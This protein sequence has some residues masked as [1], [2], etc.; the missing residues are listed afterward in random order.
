MSAGVADERF[1][2]DPAVPSV[3]RAFGLGASMLLGRGGEASVY[4]LDEERV[5]RIHRHGPTETTIERRA[6]L[7]EAL[8]THA[9]EL[10]FAIPR[11]LEAHSLHERWVTIEPRLPGHSLAN[12]LQ[13]AEDA[14]RRAL[15]RSYLDA[16][17]LLSNLRCPGSFYGD[18]L[19]DDAIRTSSFRDYAQRRARRSLD[20]AGGHLA[21]L[22][23]AELARAL[24]EPPS[25]TFVYLD[26]HPSNVLV[27]GDRI[28]AVIDFGGAAIAGDAR[29]G[30]T[31]ARP[32]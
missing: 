21:A 29:F 31:V 12:A 3:L 10:P 27:H 32:I 6:S 14:D 16:V 17:R 19:V 2:E 9:R 13:R 23:A 18:L 4:A 15:L 20:T 11:V 5:L 25:P 24:P 26:A 1:P 28:S 30:A 8:A 7:L 22:D